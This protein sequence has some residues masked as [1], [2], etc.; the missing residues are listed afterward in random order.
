METE[1]KLE[2][3]NVSNMHTCP[4]HSVHQNPRQRRHVWGWNQLWLSCFGPR[5]SWTGL[6]RSAAATGATEQLTAGGPRNILEADKSS[7]QDVRFSDQV[8]VQRVDQVHNEAG[9]SGSS[10]V[11][12]QGILVLVLLIKVNL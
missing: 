2:A 4:A 10:A 12:R 8:D 3:R 6:G 11:T 9:N 7:S 1:D 5:S